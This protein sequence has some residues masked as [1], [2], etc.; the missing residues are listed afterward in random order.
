MKKRFA[1]LLAILMLFGMLAVPAAATES[2]D[3]KVEQWN[4]VLS[5]DIGANFCLNVPAELADGAVVNVTIAGQTTAY[6][7][8][9]PNEK[10]LYLIPVRV[11][12]AQMTQGI[13]LQ[14]VTNGTQYDIGTYTIQEYAATILA[15]KYGN[16]T[17]AL[18]K[19]M[20]NYGAAAQQY[21]AVNTDNLAN[22][23]YALTEEIQLPAEYPALTVSGGLDGVRFYG[24]S[25][26]MDNR[27]AVRYYF[28]ADNVADVAFTANGNTYEAK[29]KNGL[30]YVEVPGILPQNYSQNILLTAQ[31]GDE[32]LEISYSPLTYIVRMSEKGTATMQALVKAMYGY[33][34]A[35]VSYLNNRD[36]V[37]NLPAITGGTVTT[38]QASYVVGDTVNL[39]V[40]PDEGNVQKLYIN[41][42]PL[43]LDYT[44]GQ[45]SFVATE[46]VYD[47]TGSFEPKHNWFWTADWN[48]IN[49]A[50]GVAYA[51][52]HT[53]GTQRSGDL[54]PAK[55]LYNSVSVLAKDASFGEQK[56]FA[57]VLKI[58]LTDGKK[59][60]VRLIDRDDNGKYCLQAMGD[61]F[62]SWNT[63]YWL[64]DAENAAVLNGDGVWYNMHRYGTTVYLHINGKV[65]AEID[66]AAKGVTA[67]TEIDQLKIQTYNFGYAAEIPYEFKMA[68]PEVEVKLP[69]VENGTVTADKESYVL[70]DTVTLT[71]TPNKNFA[72]KLYIDGQPL[73]LDYATGQY[74]FVATKRA[75][76]I[77][78]SFEP[79]IGWFWTSEWNLSNQAHGIIHA[80]AETGH[81]QRTG[82]LV[83]TVGACD[84]VSVLFKDV[85]GGAQKEFAMVLKMHFAGGLKAEVR[86]LDRD[87]NGK[88]CLQAMGDS[89]SGWNT[90][91]WLSAAENEAVVHGDG[92]WYSMTREGEKLYLHI[93]GH[94][95]KEINISDK[96]LTADT[97]LEQ[98]KV[99][100]YNFRNAVDIP[101]IF[102][103]AESAAVEVN[104]P[105]MENG[106]VTA[107]KE[108]F[109]EGDVVILNIA[110]DAGYT[111]KL[112]INGKPLML[113]WKKTSYSFIATESVYEITGSF[114]PVP[115][116]T[117]GDGNRWD[118]NNYG[119][120]VLNAY[121]PANSDSW[122]IDISGEY[123]SFA[124]IARNALPVEDTMDG[125]DG[126]VGFATVLRVKMDNG[127]SY[128]FRIYNDKGTYAYQECQISGAATNWANWKN[129]HHLADRIN[130]EGVELKLVRSGINKL[131]LYVDGVVMQTY[132]MEGVTAA[133]KMVSV[134]VQQNGNKGEYVAIP[135]VLQKDE[136][137]PAVTVN[138]A[139]MTGGTVTADQE[140]YKLGDIV[141][142]T[143]T[144]DDGNVQQLYINGKALML[145]YATGQYSFMVEEDAYEITGGFVPKASWFW[146][147]NWNLINQGHGVAHAPAGKE[148][149]GDL[150]P[151]KNGTI[152]MSA[153]VRDVSHG[154]QKDYAIVLK[155]AFVD[156]KK[157]EVRLID[158]DD[159]GK[160]YLQVMGNNIMGNWSALYAL[161]DAENAAVKNGAGVWYGMKREGDLLR[162][163]INDQVVKELDLTTVGITAD[164]AIDQVKLNAYNFGYATDVPYIV[165]KA[166]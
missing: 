141:N 29:A 27:V 98:V 55:G 17:K 20:L 5:D 52:A 142:L 83:P 162:L 148:S 3:V 96:G 2:A 7:L 23:G 124:V 24:A 80:P 33:H 69:T 45:Y 81:D 8:P 41:G 78:G 90:L 6:S 166:E 112:Y 70:G 37:I 22:A 135:F 155:M 46:E 157:A 18:V 132:T 107:N 109:K 105:T 115:T 84:G 28:A 87:D 137:R 51:P 93:N 140:S 161:T 92:V 25:L 79:T 126:S 160:Y 99:Q 154:D 94:I 129:I 127:K 165:Y 72:Q 77:T 111:Q 63:L 31:K 56:E 4:I 47:I 14:L 122:W 134:G 114:E 26:V 123:Y 147:A 102:R 120:G 44:T 21:F 88:Y 1:M 68:V 130:G 34:Q 146:T 50:H 149:S 12:A 48:L 159:N 85:T 39:T 10:G 113:D 89:F 13:T 73:M 16:N 156:G 101:Y 116:V 150:V 118:A 100:I 43:L 11:A 53:D 71:V 82:D 64:T 136:D 158:R 153:L 139:D 66:M 40:T 108:S 59:C 75:Y 35:A 30:F 32:K 36:A 42:E 145:D 61:S 54:V 49:E 133:N 57:I 97:A 144:P 38:D 62:S 152:G 119:H 117:P 164:V 106:T 74:S 151:E 110:P 125:V 9:A 104:I 103:M 121:Y 67:E 65:V 58:Q 131:T 60:E 128:T 95:V 91:Y 143:I 163:T 138:I 19:H 76:E 86:L 15:G